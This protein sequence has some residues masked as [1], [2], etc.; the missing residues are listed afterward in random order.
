MRKLVFWFAISVVVG[1]AAGLIFAHGVAP[2]LRAGARR[3]TEAYLKTNFKSTV[4]LGDFHVSVFP[5]VHAT[6]DGVVLHYEGRTDIP[7]LIQVSRVTLDAGFFGILRPHPMIGSV[8]LDGLQIH[9]PPHQQGEQSILHGTDEDLASKYPV[10]IGEVR[11][12]NA[13]LV[14]L[15]RDAA[16]RPR[17]FVLHYLEL[18]SVDLERPA[19]FHAILT[20][21]VPKGEI[22]SSGTFG[23]WNAED[24]GGT[25]AN[26]TYKFENAD[27][28]TLNGLSGILSS[29]GKFSGPLNYLSVE[30]ETDTPDF[31]LRTSHHPLPLHTDF[32]AIVDGTNGNTILESVVAKF[33][34][35]TLNVDGEVV[36]KTK[37]KGR[38]ILLNAVATQARVEDLLCLAVCSDPPV[39]TGVARLRAKIDIG[40]GDEDL[41]ERLRL[42]AQFDTADTHFM[43]SQTQQKV[44][45]L[46]LKAQGRPDEPLNADPV[47]HLKGEFRVV[48]GVITFSY[49]AFSV[50]GASIALA[51]TYDVDSGQLDFRGKLRM[52]AKLSQTTTGMK[53]LFLK[54]LDPFFR[55]KDGGT[56]L[57][58][59]ITGTKDKPE[60]GLD[61]HD[62]LNRN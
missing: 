19:N 32:S 18:H 16:K 46:S 34:H 38:T 49:L 51:G 8:R 45:K 14:I 1:S 60:F 42:N 40:E 2:E 10:T 25:P 3:R 9:I 20:N 56:E 23:P 13:M 62:K 33:L 11:A 53:S 36:D 30:G 12:D 50:T 59:K 4:E 58:I 7:P 31:S 54:A 17:E 28:G 41:I 35:S 24:P 15:P 29:T 43:G 37:L 5:R 27:L 52:N 44:E 22:D 6:V 61:L 21:P 57:P 26:G 39:M 48:K 47:S 55:G